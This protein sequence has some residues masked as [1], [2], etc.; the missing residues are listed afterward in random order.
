MASKAV[1]RDDFRSAGVVGVGEVGVALC[2]HASPR[3]A[4]KMTEYP[5]TLI[6]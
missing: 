1:E 5:R 3:T 6:S 4:T 2:P